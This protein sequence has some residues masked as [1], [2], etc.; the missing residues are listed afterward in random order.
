[1]KVVWHIVDPD[2]EIKEREMTKI[3]VSLLNARW[4]EK[5][6][7]KTYHKDLTQV[8]EIVKTKLACL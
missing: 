2:Q 8:M 3:A 6:F 1:M 5:R 4:I 7:L